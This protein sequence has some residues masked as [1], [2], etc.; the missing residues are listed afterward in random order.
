MV[1][2]KGDPCPLVEDGKV[3]GKPTFVVK[4]GWCSKHY[5]RFRVH[6]DPLFKTRRYEPQGEEC[7]HEDCHEKPKR[8]SLCEKHA[9]LMDK[10][11]ETTNSRERR[12]WAKVDK[13]GPLPDESPD[14]GPCWVWTGYIDKN[15]GYGQFGS[16]GNGS[17]LPH[18]IAYEYLREPIPKGKHLDH[19]C[20][21]RACCRPSHLEPVTPRENIRRGDQGAFWGYIPE[22]IPAK[23]VQLTLSVCRNGC[24]KPVYKRDLCRPCYRKW[25]KDPDA[26]RPSQRTTEQRFW[27]KVAKNGPVPGHRPD[28]GPCWVWTASINAKT[29]YGRFGVRHGE[30]MDA[31]RFSYLLAHETIPEKH[32]VHH[33]CHL[34]RC[35]NPAHLLATTRSENLRM[36]KNRRDDA[37]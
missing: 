24:A 2:R 3:C 18:R 8:Q 25:L 14:L 22:V 9:R 33:A 26:E 7:K 17:N 37:A 11:G 21:R 10:Y 20:R 34:R 19:L 12:F 15:T 4:Y 16:K 23:P 27:G 29:G 32:D 35:V 30:M 36:R 5:G 6:G 28:L 13:N 31:H 1:V